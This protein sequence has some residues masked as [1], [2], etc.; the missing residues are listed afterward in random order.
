[1]VKWS[2]CTEFYDHSEAKTEVVGRVRRGGV[3]LYA[4]LQRDVPAG[5]F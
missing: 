5:E 1:M 3:S 2:Q 4:S